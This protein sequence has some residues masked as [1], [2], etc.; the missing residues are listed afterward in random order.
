MERKLFLRAANEKVV[1][2]IH[3]PS[4]AVLDVAVV[5][6]LRRL[7]FRT[8]PLPSLCM[9]LFVNRNND[10]NNTNTVKTIQFFL[11]F[12]GEEIKDNTHLT[13]CIMKYGATFSLH[14]LL[15]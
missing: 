3:F 15:N 6:T 5:F 13:A 10:K 14:L 2:K 4:Q 7:N 1:R 11:L 8:T 12:S 9:Q